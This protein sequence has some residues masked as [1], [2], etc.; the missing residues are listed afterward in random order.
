MNRTYPA[1]ISKRHAFSYRCDSMCLMI[2]HWKQCTHTHTHTMAPVYTHEC[3]CSRHLTFDF[4]Q[5]FSG[6]LTL[7]L[8]CLVFLLRARWCVCVCVR[9]RCFHSIHISLNIHVKMILINFTHI[10]CI[11]TT[12]FYAVCGCSVDFLLL[13]VCD[14]RTLYV[15]VLS[16]SLMMCV[17]VCECCF[18]PPLYTLTHSLTHST[19]YATLLTCYIHITHYTTIAA[20]T[21]QHTQREKDMYICN[22]YTTSP[23]DFWDEKHFLFENLC[24]TCN[25][26]VC[27]YVPKC[28]FQ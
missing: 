20:I 7:V 28:V 18:S 25:T 23:V 21:I 13:F 8:V 2:I 26:Y 16:F 1:S 15:M 4:S 11:N 6:A 5:M 17:C 19:L 3:T 14:T 12:V 10:K 24:S 22:A 9:V 27:V